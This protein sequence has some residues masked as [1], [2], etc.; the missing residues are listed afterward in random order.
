MYSPL[1]LAQKYLKYY[2]TASNG[3]GHGIHSPFVYD[4]VTRVLNDTQAYPC[5]KSIEAERKKLLQNKNRI[6]VQDFGAGSAV[7]ATNK[8][9]IK[10]I[11]ASSLKPAKYA[12]LLYRI[13]QYFQP[14]TLLEL[15]TSLGITSSYM[16]SANRSGKLFTCEGSPE[17]AQI[18]Q[19]VFDTLQLKNISLVEG[20]FRDTLQPLLQKTGNI[21]FAFI[22]GHHRKEP[23]LLYFQQ[24]LKNCHSK[25]I[26]IFDDIHWSKEMEE[27]WQ[28][29]KAHSAVTLSI[30][31]FFIGIVF[32]NK[33]FKEKQDFII[34][35]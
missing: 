12:Q 20:N 29:I 30:D 5:Y 11:A 7:I 8:R 21:D 26:V 9:P 28:N 13:V 27:A 6:P 2:C 16:A 23:T 22:D 14:A 19:Q 18:A 25:S 35:F 3:K 15:G 10:K 4:F 24:I 31:L 33:D 17:I 34:R 32:F 1:Q